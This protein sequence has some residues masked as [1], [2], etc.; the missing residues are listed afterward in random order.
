MIVPS[1]EEVEDMLGK[2]ME[3]FL[4]KYPEPQREAVFERIT[5]MIRRMAYP[6]TPRTWLTER[7]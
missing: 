6:E 7:S 3:K 2:Q 5:E 1:N 4:E